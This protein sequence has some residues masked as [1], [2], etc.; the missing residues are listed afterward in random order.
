MPTFTPPTDS[1]QYPTGSRLLDRMRPKRGL[2]VYTTDAGTTWRQSVFPLQSDLVGD[3][4]TD[5]FLGGH[6]YTITAGQATALTAAGF[7]AYIT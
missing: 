7:G 1:F 3:E 2:T 6:V 4:G 5:W